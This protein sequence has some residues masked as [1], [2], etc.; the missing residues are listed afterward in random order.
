MHVSRALLR[1]TRASIR[2]HRKFLVFLVALLVVIITLVMIC[3]SG[4]PQILTAQTYS[5]GGDDDSGSGE[6]GAFYSYTQEGEPT[7]TPT[8]TPPPDPTFTPHDVTPT[9]PVVVTPEYSGIGA[10][11]IGLLT[12]F[13]AFTLFMVR[14]KVT[15]KQNSESTA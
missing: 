6:T 12:C 8:T 5:T 13:V 1:N 14:G 4:I 3:S 2:F 9:P 7:A 15:R 11:L 10:G